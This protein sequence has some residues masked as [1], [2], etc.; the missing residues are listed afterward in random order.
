MGKPVAKGSFDRNDS[1]KKVAFYS[2]ESVYSDGAIKARYIRLVAKNGFG[3]DP[4]T[5]I[6][7]LDIITD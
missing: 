1:L 3:E 7:E 2:A 4:Y 6:A 5:T